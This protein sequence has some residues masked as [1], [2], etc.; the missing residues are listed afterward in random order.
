MK[1]KITGGVY[2]NRILWVADI[3]NGNGKRIPLGKVYQNHGQ[4]MNMLKSINLCECEVRS[5]IKFLKEIE[6][7]D[8]SPSEKKEVR[9]R[10]QKILKKRV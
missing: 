8:L 1:I 2:K 5:G 7:V 3:E 9:S 6:I 4:L 10:L